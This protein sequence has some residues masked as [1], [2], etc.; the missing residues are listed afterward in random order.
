MYNSMRGYNIQNKKGHC[1]RCKLKIPFDHLPSDAYR[2]CSF[3]QQANS[4]YNVNATRIAENKEAQAKDKIS[5]QM[6]L[7]KDAS[8]RKKMEGIESQEKKYRDELMEKAILYQMKQREVR[9]RQ[10]EKASAKNEQKTGN[11]CSSC[12]KPIYISHGFP[13]CDCSD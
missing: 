6:K 8:Q 12:G 13:R 10:L 9:K 2:L 4:F 1:S 5:L 3:C 11:V 7:D